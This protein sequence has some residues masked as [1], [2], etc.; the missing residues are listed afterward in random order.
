[1]MNI[2]DIID[3]HSFLYIFIVTPRDQAS[4]HH[5]IE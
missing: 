2:L 3:F 1:M 4:W 5:F